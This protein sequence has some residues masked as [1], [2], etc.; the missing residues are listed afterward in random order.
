LVAAQRMADQDRVAALRVE[1]AISLIRNR[2]RA[3]IDAAIEPQRLG[4]GEAVAG[5]VG[6]GT[7]QQ[8][9]GQARQRS[10]LDHGAGSAA[11][12]PE[13]RPRL[14]AARQRLPNEKRL[15]RKRG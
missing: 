1:P 8:G 13:L 12:R 7:L 14:A 15:A 11:G 5:P 10:T 6:P 4:D 9:C 3:E 2:E